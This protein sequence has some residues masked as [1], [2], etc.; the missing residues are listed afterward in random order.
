MNE[1]PVKKRDRLTDREMEIL[2]DIA[3][4]LS[5]KDIAAKYSIAVN[6]A[7]VHRHNIIRKTHCANTTEAA[8]K[9]ARFSNTPNPF[10]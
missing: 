7:K 1:M 6:T 8:V 9:Y 3:S 2:M 4:G 5:T 10:V